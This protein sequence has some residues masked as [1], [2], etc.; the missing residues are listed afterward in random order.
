MGISEFHNAIC[1][2]TGDVEVAALESFT[3]YFFLLISI[4]A[5]SLIYLH[6][7]LLLLSGIRKKR[8]FPYLIHVRIRV[9]PLKTNLYSENN[10]EMKPLWTT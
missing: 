1:Q 6:L 10:S 4:T 7:S 2:K 5:V 3:F 9:A 8:E